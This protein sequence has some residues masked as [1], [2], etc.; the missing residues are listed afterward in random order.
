MRFVVALLAV[1]LAV[2]AWA[3]CPVRDPGAV[4]RVIAKGHAFE[5]HRREYRPGEIYAGTDYQAPA[6]RT[7]DQ[8]ADLV[9]RN[10]TQPD[11]ERK[12]ARGRR[13]FWEEDYGGLVIFDPNNPDCGTAFRPR[14]G[15]AYF[16][17][18]R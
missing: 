1:L 2:P 9:T 3:A 10:L 7:Q 13:A 6:I 17:D 14:R 5:K 11:V 12:L 15:K 8:F 18:L 4:A 16:D